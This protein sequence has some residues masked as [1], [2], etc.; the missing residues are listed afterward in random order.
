MGSDIE[1]F[2]H[3]V[4]ESILHLGKSILKGVTNHIRA[5]RFD[6]EDNRV[7]DEK[8]RKHYRFKRHGFKYYG[9]SVGF[10]NKISQR[11]RLIPLSQVHQHIGVAGEI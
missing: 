3:S 1:E 5:A 7:I 9:V 6:K 11:L 8:A 10:S 4:V 2:R